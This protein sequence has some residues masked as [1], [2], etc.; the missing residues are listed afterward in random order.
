[1]LTALALAATA[2]EDTTLEIRQLA[3]RTLD[4]VDTMADSRLPGGTLSTDLWCQL[5]EATASQ[6]SPRV[7]FDRA[8]LGF[9]EEADFP[10]TV[11][12]ALISA[13]R[14]ALRNAIS[15]ASADTVKASCSLHAGADGVLGG[16]SFP[17]TAWDLT[18]RRWGWTGSESRTRS[19]R[20]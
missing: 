16:W 3:S 1:M 13:M 9:T 2:S 11:V 17:T 10:A 15:H 7:Q 6:V 8:P 20:E 4:Q 18:P 19:S 14:E 5:A 12:E